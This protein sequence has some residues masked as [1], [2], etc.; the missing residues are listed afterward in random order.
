MML[1]GATTYVRGALIFVAQI[2]GGITAAAVVSAMMPKELSCR[3]SL[4][5]GTT[6]VQGLFIEV[7]RS[8]LEKAQSSN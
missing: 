7:C 8:S 6:V 2:L 3:T 5:G 1:V 4:G